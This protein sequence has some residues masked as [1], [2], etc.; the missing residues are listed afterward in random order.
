MLLFKRGIRKVIPGIVIPVINTKYIPQFIS[1]DDNFREMV[2]NN[3]E[4]ARCHDTQFPALL[5][6]AG[7]L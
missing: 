1:K 7:I 5:F 3:G 4:H 6:P 2:A